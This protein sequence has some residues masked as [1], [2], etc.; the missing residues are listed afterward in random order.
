MTP[1]RSNTLNMNSQDGSN[2]VGGPGSSTIG[3]EVFE[4]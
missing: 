3:D 4:F 2:D 1:F